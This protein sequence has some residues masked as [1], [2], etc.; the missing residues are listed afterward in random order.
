MAKKAKVESY[1]EY[2]IEGLLTYAGMD[3]I[4]TSELLCSIFSKVIDKP[5]YSLSNKGVRSVINAPSILQEAEEVKMVINEFI[6]D[7]EVNGFKYDIEGNTS[8]AERMKGELK[9]LEENIYRHIPYKLNLDSG[10]ELSKLL[11]GHFKFDVPAY[12]KTGAPSTD[13]DAIKI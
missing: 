13:G 2:D 6:I 9:S 11:Y 3:C 1:E 4:C 12:T 10:P 5:G 7:L 8:L